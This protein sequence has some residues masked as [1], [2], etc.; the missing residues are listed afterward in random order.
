MR[1]MTPFPHLSLRAILALLVALTAWS[2]TS[3]AMPV[4]ARQ[5]EMSCAACHDAYP[6]LNDFGAYFRD[7]N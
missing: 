4:F 6:R 1:V 2:A 5:Y 3:Q 7:S